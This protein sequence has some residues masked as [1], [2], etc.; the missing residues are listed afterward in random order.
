VIFR[1]VTW[2]SHRRDKAPI[3][4]LDSG[5]GAYGIAIHHY[6]IPVG[7]GIMSVCVQAVCYIGRRRFPISRK[8]YSSPEWM[9]S[10]AEK[11]LCESS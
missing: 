4:W 6:T 7:K 10:T 1:L 2:I 11:M 5:Q 9:Q 3:H 8:H